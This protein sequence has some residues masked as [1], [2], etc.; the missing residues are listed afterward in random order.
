[1]RQGYMIFDR[2]FSVFPSYMIRLTSYFDR[3]YCCSRCAK[4]VLKM[5]SK[6][7]N[8]RPTVYCS[9]SSCVRRHAVISNTA[10]AGAHNA[11]WHVSTDTF[12]ASRFH[13]YICSSVALPGFGGRGTGGLGRERVPGAQ[14]WWGN[15]GQSPL[16]ELTAYYGYLVAKP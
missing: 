2:Y 13:V 15:G 14:P 4:N 3:F 8:F 16:P 9:V 10:F 6:K 1:M 11:F 7:S 12:L 5:N